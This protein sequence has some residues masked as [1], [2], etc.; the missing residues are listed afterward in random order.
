MAQPLP[1]GV[2]P[3]ASVTDGSYLY[4]VGYDSN[5]LKLYKVS[6]DTYTNSGTAEVVCELTGIY[7]SEFITVDETNNKLYISDNG[8]GG[9]SGVWVVDLGSG[10]LGQFVTFDNGVY[11]TGLAVYGGYLYVTTNTP[12]DEPSFTNQINLIKIDVTNSS[13]QTSLAIGT[14]GTYFSYQMVVHNYENNPYTGLYCYFLCNSVDYD[15]EEQNASRVTRV[16]LN[17]FTSGGVTLVYFDIYSAFSGTTIYVASTLVYNPSAGDF[18]SFV[19]TTTTHEYINYIGQIDITNPSNPALTSS[20]YIPTVSN[21]NYSIKSVAVDSSGNFIIDFQNSYQIYGLPNYLELTYT[22]IPLGYTLTLPISTDGTITQ[23][24][25]G[26]GNSDTSYSHTYSTAGTYTVTVDAIDITQLNQNLGTGAQYLTSCGNFGGIGLTN[27]TDAFD[28]C[29]TL[30]VVPYSLPLLSTITN[31]SGMFYGASS[32]NQELGWG[33]YVSSV[34]DISYMFYGA[35]SFNQQLNGW[36]FGNVTDMSNMF[37]GASAFNNGNQTQFYFQVNTTTAVNMSGMFQ[38]AVAFNQSINYTAFITSSVIDMSNMFNGAILFNDANVYSFNV[39]NVT[40]M[41]GMFKGATA[42]NKSLSGW[43]VSNVTDMSYMFQNAT[44]FN[45]NIGVWDISAVTNIISMFDVSGLSIANYDNILNT[46]SGKTVMSSLDFAGYGIVYSPYGETGHTTLAS[47]PKSWVFYGDALVSTDEI[48]KNILF[49][50]TVN[51]TSSTFTAG[52]YQLYYNGAVFSSEVTYDGS[53]AT[54]PIFDNLQFTTNVYRAPIVLKN[55]TTNSTV[56]T[57]YLSTGGPLILTYTGLPSEFELKLPIFIGGGTITKVDWGDGTINQT[58]I[59]TYGN[60]GPYTVSVK[61]YGTNISQLTYSPYIEYSKTGQE[62][63]TSCD[64]FGEIGLTELSNA[65]NQCIN[66]TTVPENLPFSSSVT[67]TVYMFE[68]ANSFNDVNVTTW[69][70]S[71]VINMSLMFSNAPIFNQDISSWD[72]SNVTYMGGTFQNAYAFNNGGNPLSWGYKTSKLISI[73]D[74]FRNASSFNQ[75]ISGWDLSN[76]TNMS[77]MF[78]GATAF[79]NGDTTDIASKPLTLTLNT[80]D[81]IA[82][83]NMFNGATSFNQYITWNTS[84]VT[85]MSS[86]F[87]S[88]NSFNQDVNSWDV[89]S[90]TNMVNMF[91]LANSFDQNLVVWDISNVT[92]LSNMLNYSGLSVTNYDSTL[93]SWGYLFPTPVTVGL[94]FAGY[95]LVYSPTGKI[96]HDALETAYSWIFDLDALVSTDTVTQGTPFDF[97]INSY[98]LPA[99]DYSL[100]YSG[101]TTES[102]SY[103][104]GFG[105]IPF[106]GL[107]FTENGTRLPIVLNTISSTIPYYLDVEPAETTTSLILTYRVPAGGFPSDPTLTLPL[108]GSGSSITSVDWGDGTIDTSLSHTYTNETETDYTI[109]FSGT[110]FTSFNYNSTRSQNRYLISCTSFGEIGLTSL[111]SA[112]Y[113]CSNLTTVPSSLPTTSTITNMSEMFY[114]TTVFNQSISSWDVS[115]VTTM[116]NMFFQ[117]TSFNQS[118]SG[119]NV[120]S[121]VNMS[122]MFSNAYAFNNGGETLTWATGGNTSQV[123]DMSLMFINASVFNQD[124]SSWDVSS[125]ENMFDMFHDAN[126]F[127]N[128]GVDLDWNDTSKVTNMSQMFW[129]AYDFNQPLSSWNTSSVTNMYAMFVNATNFNQD[130]SVWDVS[131]VTNMSTMFQGATNFNNGGVDLDWAD[132]SKVTD[133]REMF[134]SATNFNQSVSTWNVSKVTTMYFMFYQASAFN[135]DISSWTLNTTEGETVDLGNMFTGATAFNNGDT[136]GASTKPL[137]NFVTS[138]VNSVTSMFG[139]ASAFNQDVSGWNFTNITYLY[140]LFSGATSFNQPLNSWD[141]S[142][143]TATGDMFGGATSFNKPLDL[144]NVS[145]ITDISYMFAGASSFSQDLSQWNVQT[146]DYIGN[147]F[148]N[149]G[150]SVTNYN[151]ILTGWGAQTVIQELDFYGYGLV[152]SP[153][154]LVGHNQL[155]EASWVFAGDAYV[156]EN[157]VKTNTDYTFTVNAPPSEFSDGVY[158]LYYNGKYSSE[159]TY[160]SGVDTTIPFTINFGSSGNRLPIVLKYTTTGGGYGD[161]SDVTTYYLDVYPNTIVCFKE[162]TKILTDKGYIP[163]QDLRNGDLVKTLLDGYKPIYMIAKREIYHSALEERIKDQL[164]KC[165]NEKYPEIFEDLIITG[166]HSVLVDNFKDDQRENTSKLLGKIFSTGKKYRLP[167][168][169]DEKASVYEKEGVYTVYHLALEN[170][171]YTW[172]YGIYANGLLVESCSKRYLKEMSNM[173]VIE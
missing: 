170:E 1:N 147:V 88:A 102:V 105:T 59:H 108:S 137:T 118:I 133:M 61:V 34:T 23:V 134:R 173:T 123:T 94:T 141:V 7:G 28:S 144:W 3:Q 143:I 60:A 18:L 53:S 153:S 10:T 69:D 40:N 139:S 163:I 37:K 98:S 68:G 14:G 43:D 109:T 119:W 131:S 80:T 91:T 171:N 52:L 16:D 9:P 79:N 13:L 152:Y 41:S 51:T 50:L 44:S 47:S 54:L 72:V 140:S 31:M 156:S 95:G 164:Y 82:M 62:Y 114:G 75:D 117:A 92:D 49:D 99:G 130:V 113:F 125:V 104:G 48:T 149:S 97:T 96:G 157:I 45:Q 129:S 71:T 106:A 120:S 39:S 111:N 148:D 26:D 124:I 25:W 103:A 138:N 166:C 101:K 169:L 17:N 112:F 29:T 142:T 158:Q 33:E 55:N 12:S 76:I 77:A 19:Y 83:A 89:S 107:I 87:S 81:G 127:N 65:F 8:D 20:D 132:T 165:T 64:S 116:Y 86:M 5:V 57:Y 128:G 155:S 154:G 66:L 38:D 2:Y 56:T 27:L 4:V 168:C 21:L 46:W 145:N 150:L 151:N 100:T 146:M 126:N 73:G 70:V 35:T 167:V 84:K 121:V 85:T 93:N 90:V 63:L 22:N 32:F 30:T 74:M 122:R 160:T 136:S 42:F 110:G 11:P 172:N 6:T 67:S 78:L 159:V 24:N 161:T 15:T 135:Q 58:I 36:S 115:S 162:D